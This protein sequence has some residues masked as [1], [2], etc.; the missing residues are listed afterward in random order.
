MK[1]KEKIKNTLIGDKNKIIINSSKK[2]IVLGFT[3]LTSGICCLIL[4]LY[5][6]C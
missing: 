2:D 4:S 1:K 5:Y 6:D 3:L